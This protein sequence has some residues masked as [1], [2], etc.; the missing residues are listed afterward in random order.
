[1]HM[2]VANATDFRTSFRVLVGRMIAD[3]KIRILRPEYEMLLALYGSD[4]T[5]S[6]HLPAYCT[7]AGSTVR[8]A[9]RSGLIRGVITAAPCTIDQR[10]V[11]YC[12]TPEARRQ[13]ESSLAEMERWFAEMLEWPRF[14]PSVSI[15]AIARAVEARL[16]VRMLTPEHKLLL[17]VYETG[18]ICS[19]QLLTATRFAQSTVFAALDKLVKL[20]LIEQVTDPEDGRRKLYRLPDGM[21][22]RLDGYHRQILNLI[23]RST[24]HIVAPPTITHHAASLG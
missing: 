1:M 24:P 2:K 15:S 10:E 21:R 12:L 17:L 22:E 20:A 23:D 16:R 14:R 8:G 3:L 5:P 4:P 19:S 9:I 13:L 7:W 18:S 11:L 6:G